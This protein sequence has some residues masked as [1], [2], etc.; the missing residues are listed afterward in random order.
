MILASL[1]LI[2]WHVWAY[3]PTDQSARPELLLRPFPVLLGSE[4][5]NLLV[6]RHGILAELWDVFPYFIVG[7]LLAG[8]IRTFK[9][10]LKLQASLKRYGILSV[11]IASLVGMITPLCAC[12]TLTT[13]ISLLFARFPL[14]PSWRSW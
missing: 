1:S 6:D 11:F 3:G 8:Y 7:I 13:A 10:A 9:I 12:G 2:I 14:A 5:W 4:I